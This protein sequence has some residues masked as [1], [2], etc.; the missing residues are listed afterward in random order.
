M[1]KSLSEKI[2]KILIDE[3]QHDLEKPLGSQIT[4]TPDE[5]RDIIKKYEAELSK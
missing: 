5:V 1:N 4:F 3:G 2:F